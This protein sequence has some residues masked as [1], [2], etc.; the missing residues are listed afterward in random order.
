MTKKKPKGPATREALEVLTEAETAEVL[1]SA[2]AGIA[3]RTAD[4]PA[5][6]LLAQYAPVIENPEAVGDPAVVP[7]VVLP[8]GKR[9]D[10]GFVWELDATWTARVERMATIA[11]LPLERYLD[12]LLRRAWVGMDQRHRGRL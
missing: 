7:S 1:A 10:K 11:G 4:N 9:G 5:G 6:L 2:P 8:V 3:P 12:S